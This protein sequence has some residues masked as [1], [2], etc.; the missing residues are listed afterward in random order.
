MLHFFNRFSATVVEPSTRSMKEAR[1]R[2]DWSVLSGELMPLMEL[3]WRVALEGA[4]AW[5]T[6]NF[7]D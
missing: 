6:T 4:F 5:T 3:K 1:C 7:R 2:G